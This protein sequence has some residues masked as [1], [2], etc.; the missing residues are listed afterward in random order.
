M[1][2]PAAQPQ[3]G[4]NLNEFYLSQGCSEVVNLGTIEEPLYSCE[5]CLN[6]YAKA[7]FNS[8]TGQ[9]NCY[10]RR[11]NFWYCLEGIIEETGEQNVQN[12]LNLP[13]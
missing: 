2:C 10:E 4:R 3:S 9:K 12:V 8:T 7:I 11:N 13:L 5:Q 6:N 1:C